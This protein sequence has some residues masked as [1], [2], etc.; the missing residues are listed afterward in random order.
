MATTGKAH[1]GAARTLF[2]DLDEARIYA[3]WR[4]EPAAGKPVL[5]FLHDGLGCTA[6]LRLLPDLVGDALDV[7]VFTY[8][9]WGYGQSDRRDTFP[10]DL[11]DQEAAILPRVLDAVGIEDCC[12][13]GHSD[14]GTIALLH[15]ATNPARVRA[16]VAIAAHIFFDEQTDIILA[17]HQKMLDDGNIPEFLYRFHGDRGPHV[18]WCWTGIGR[19]PGYQGWNIS[20]RISTI[21][22][23]L[24]A[25]QGAEDDGGTQ[26][27]VAGIGD[28]V[29]HAKT[30]LLPGI[31]HFPHVED[32]EGTTHL[33][34][35]FLA[36]YCR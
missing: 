22:G 18:L 3:E 15:A 26:A 5:V 29:P 1:A 4:R 9:R 11:W 13:V 25:V 8:D 6:S 33:I 36:P 27:Q 31:G 12:L 21:K 30:M 35:D 2:V 19:D 23:P 16:T 24:F 17:K 14:G 28:A 32:P 7:G 34:A 20:P 10:V